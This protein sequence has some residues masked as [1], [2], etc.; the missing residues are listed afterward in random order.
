MNAMQEIKVNGMRQEIDAWHRYIHFTREGSEYELTLYW[1][2]FNGFEIMWRSANGE[3]ISKAP[4][5]ANEWD[6]GDHNE[7]LAWWLDELT[8]E[9]EGK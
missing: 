9:M 3:A 1:D 8:Y 7:S 4:K 2:Q 5:W 6:E